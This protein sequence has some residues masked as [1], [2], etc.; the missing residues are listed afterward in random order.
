M[1]NSCEVVAKKTIS[2]LTDNTKYDINNLIPNYEM[3]AAAAKADKDLDYDF[4]EDD[5]D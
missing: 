2:F 1:F 4:C 5:E 3:V